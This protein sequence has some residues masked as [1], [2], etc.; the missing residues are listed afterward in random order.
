MNTPMNYSKWIPVNVRVLRGDK[1]LKQ[2]AEL[3][4]L[5]ISYLSDIERGRTLPSID[6]LDKIFT[7]CGATLV[8]GYQRDYTPPD[9]L[10]IKR[11]DAEALKALCRRIL[12]ESEDIS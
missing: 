5:S 10:Y 1:T 8:I 3:T 9:Y 4:G 11:D 12:G 6:T 2:L 7:A